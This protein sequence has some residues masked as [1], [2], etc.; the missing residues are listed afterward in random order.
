MP[1]T[2]LPSKPG[3]DVAYGLFPGD[4]KSKLLLIFLHGLG[5]PHPVWKPTIDSLH[6]LG[7][8]PLPR[9]ITYD[10]YGQLG[11]ASARHPREQDPKK[12]PGYYHNLDDVTDDLEEVIAALSPD[13]H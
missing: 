13:R 1:T 10:C 2:T 9:M 4:S 7:F 5:A 3:A 6:Q 11:G 12:E 8:S